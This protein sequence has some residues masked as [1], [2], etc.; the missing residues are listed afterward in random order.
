[1]LPRW[2]HKIVKPH[3]PYGEYLLTF[4][5]KQFYVADPQPDSILIEDIAHGLSNLCRFVGAVKSFYSVAQHSLLVEEEVERVIGKDDWT[6]VVRLKALIHDAPEYITNDCARPVRRMIP[7]FNR[8]DSRIWNVVCQK[9]NL[10]PKWESVIADADDT[11]LLA[12][13]RDLLVPSSYHWVEQDK[14]Q[15]SAKKIVPMTPGQ[16][17]IKF[18][19]KFYQLQKLRNHES[20]NS[21]V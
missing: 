7:A 1:M 14:H 12:E 4:S 8:L 9:F 5:G 10:E 11:I 16:A 3:E 17:E 21:Q 19:E 20:D 18:L 13:R 15:A 2:L 6:V